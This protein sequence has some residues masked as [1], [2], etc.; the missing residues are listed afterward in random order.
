MNND[1][2]VFIPSVCGCEVSNQT[3]ESQKHPW[4]RHHISLYNRKQ[5]Y[6][7]VFMFRT[8]LFKFRASIKE[9]LKKLLAKLK[10]QSFSLLFY[11]P[12]IKL[13]FKQGMQKDWHKEAKFL[14]FLYPKSIIRLLLLMSK[15]I[16]IFHIKISIQFIPWRNSPNTIKFQFKL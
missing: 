9:K 14:K 12:A 4:V 5:P 10:S 11:L 1:N 15:I 6:R 13:L 16:E 7:K 3:T 2:K 8:R